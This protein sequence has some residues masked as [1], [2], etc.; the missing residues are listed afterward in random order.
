[1]NPDE[2]PTPAPAPEDAKP[3]GGQPPPGAAPTSTT[4][5]A[6]AVN[7]D[8]LFDPTERR[9]APAPEPAAAPHQKAAAAPSPNPRP[10]PKQ[11]FPDIPMPGG[12]RVG[13]MRARDA[14]INLDLDLGRIKRRKRYGLLITTTSVLFIALVLA[15][16][17]W[18][19]L[20]RFVDPPSNVLMM[21]R[22]AAGEEIRHYAVPLNR[23]SP[24]LI[25]SVIAAEDNNFCTHSGFDVEAI[26]SAM[27]SNARSRRTRGA[28]TISQQVAKN[29][30]LWPD[31]S[32]LRKGLESYFTALIEFMWPKRRIME[33]YLNIAEWGDGA[34]GAEAAARAHFGASAADLTPLQ[35]ARLAAVLPNPNRWRADRPGP[36]VRSRAATLVQRAR[37]VRNEH[38]AGCVLLLDRPPEPRRNTQ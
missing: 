1:M 8:P 29:M 17:T 25:R 12:A 7:D 2:T 16:V 36:Y 9:P 28:S 35:A 37:V 11:E 31:R 32:W 38:L 3:E 20:Y 15:P 22:A 13:G 19:G 30:F 24:H 34:F 18:V 33:A 4:D 23:V 26:E 6:Q 21:Q 14:R 10:N 27:R 5:P